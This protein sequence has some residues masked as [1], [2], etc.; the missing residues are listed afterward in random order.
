VTS[1]R[2]KAI[3]DILADPA[4][5]K[6]GV[7]A[8]L[9]SE[10]DGL[11]AEIGAAFAKA[12]GEAEGELSQ[13]RE[14]LHAQ[15]EWARTSEADKASIEVAFDEAANPV[16]TATVIGLVK[17]RASDFR[18]RAWPGLLE[19]AAKAGAPPAPTPPPTLAD[20]PM[21]APVAQPPGVS[22]R[23]AS[24]PY[25]ASPPSAP[26]FVSVTQLPVNFAKAVLADE[27]DV[28]AYLETLRKTLL[29]A[30]RGGKRISL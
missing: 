3:S 28:G 17:A 20:R 25:V 18:S 8:K 1:S 5:F 12:Y 14:A 6:S 9:K 10:L 22:D 30:I 7:T 26:T 4:C 27:A 24:E 29:A 13:L 11:R 23:L 2:A 15:P 16:R 19:R 21:A